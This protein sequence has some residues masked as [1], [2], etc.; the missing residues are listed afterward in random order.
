MSGAQELQRANACD[1]EV[2]RFH[3]YA[4]PFRGMPGAENQAS[5]SIWSSTAF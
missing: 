3:T 2:A 4:L 1:A 5:H